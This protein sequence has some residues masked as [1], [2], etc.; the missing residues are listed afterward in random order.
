[1]NL[2]IRIKNGEPFEHPITESNLKAIYKDINL[3]DLPEYVLPFIKND[4]PA[5][6]VY[7]VRNVSYIISNNTV[8]ETWTVRPMTQE[9]K[10][11]KQN[12]TKNEWYSTYPNSDA[13]FNEDTCSFMPNI[14]NSDQEPE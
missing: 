7:E 4:P 6:D 10:I 13:V 5:I 11:Q 1:M 9:E 2:Y 14:D 3:N 12:T 8:V